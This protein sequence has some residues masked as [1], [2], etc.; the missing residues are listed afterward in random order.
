MTVPGSPSWAGTPFSIIS[1]ISARPVS[2]PIGRAPAR[3]SFMPLY[4]AGL[5][6]AVNIAPGRS[7]LPLA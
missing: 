4:R 7:R 5:W 3:H 2:L 6:L 1:R